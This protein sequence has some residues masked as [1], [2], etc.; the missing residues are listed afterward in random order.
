[1]RNSARSLACTALLA[2]CLALAACGTGGPAYG[3][4]TQGVAATVD[5]SGFSYAPA[6][7]RIKAGDTVEWR[8][9]SLFAHTVTLD[10]KLAAAPAGA[11][12]FDSGR[13]AAGDVYRH[14]FAVPGT[15]RYKC[16]PHEDA[17][18]TGTVVVE[19]RS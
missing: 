2:P 8:N 15:Y 4:P 18:M 17:G 10:P 16:I 3:P 13:I 11:A 6:T 14:T 1:M 12:P 5:M 7:V 9:K 19:P